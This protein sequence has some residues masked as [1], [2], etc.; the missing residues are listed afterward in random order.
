MPDFL[1]EIGTEEIPARMIESAWREMTRRVLD[2]LTNQSLFT[3]EQAAER[4]GDPEAGGIGFFFPPH[5]AGLR[6]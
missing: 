6:S 5:R 4:V 1:L 3:I 2:L